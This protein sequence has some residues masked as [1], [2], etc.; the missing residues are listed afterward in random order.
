MKD[1]TAVYPIPDKVS[2]E[3]IS[4]YPLHYSTSSPYALT[5]FALR[6]VLYPS[7]LTHALL[8]T[9]TPADLAERESP[10]IRSSDRTL[11]WTRQE[12]PWYST[13]SGLA[14]TGPF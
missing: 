6:I 9:P 11:L 3:L 12:H 13:T 1:L 4:E 2:S 7:P 14:D 5:P 10:P 8:T